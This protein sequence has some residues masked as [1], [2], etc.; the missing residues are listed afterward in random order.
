MYHVRYR[1]V[2]IQREAPQYYDQ[3]IVKFL[4][5]PVNKLWERFIYKPIETPQFRESMIQ[6][7]EKRFVNKMYKEIQLC[8]LLYCRPVYRDVPIDQY[9]LVP[10]FVPTVK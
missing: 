5:T 6:K 3:K 1:Q 7:I 10:Q 4:D 2:P 8:F 9:R